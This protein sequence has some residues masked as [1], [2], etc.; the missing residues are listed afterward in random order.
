MENIKEIIE[1]T[2]KSISDNES[3]NAFVGNKT[4]EKITIKIIE[5][6]EKIKKI[7]GV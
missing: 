3:L 7:M 1:D 5:N 4:N 2:L 6:L